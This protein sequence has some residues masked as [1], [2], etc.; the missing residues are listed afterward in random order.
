M[1]LQYDGISYFFQFVN[2]FVVYFVFGGCGVKLVYAVVVRTEIA[3]VV[4]LEN[5]LSPSFR[6][7]PV[8]SD[9]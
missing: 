4:R 3:V 9:E 1:P 7:R 2:V 8:Q 5:Y 6:F